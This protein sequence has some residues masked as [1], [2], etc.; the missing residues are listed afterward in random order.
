MKCRWKNFSKFAFTGLGLALLGLASPVRAQ[1]PILEETQS[2]YLMP[3]EAMDIALAGYPGEVTDVKP[4]QLSDGSWLYI[5]NVKSG[6]TDREV[7]V[8][9]L[10]G[11]IAGVDYSGAGLPDDI[12]TMSQAVLD[13]PEMP[14]EFQRDVPDA[15]DLPEENSPSAQINDEGILEPNSSL[16]QP[17]DEPAMMDEEEN[18]YVAENAVVADEP[19][20]TLDEAREHAMMLYPGQI[21]SA[22][23]IE[24]EEDGSSIYQITIKSGVVVRQVNIPASTGNVAD[25]TYVNTDTEEDQ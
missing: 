14:E 7:Y 23:T 16:D 13:V 10:N 1:E 21:I 18:G 11:E 8:D 5:V 24:S 6:A 15:R 19:T 3:V 20:F 12:Q 2:T 25:V 17:S 22:S 4:M 9:A